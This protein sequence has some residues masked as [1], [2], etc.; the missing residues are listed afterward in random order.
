MS[1]TTSSSE[2]TQIETKDDEQLNL[3]KLIEIIQRQDVDIERLQQD[4]KIL[5]D[6]I[7]EMRYDN[8]V[9]QR[10][11]LSAENN[12]KTLREG[13]SATLELMFGMFK[14]LFA[15]AYEQDESTVSIIKE[16]KLSTVRCTTCLKSFNVRS[17]S[18]YTGS[19]FT[20]PDCPRTTRKFKLGAIAS[21]SK[22]TQSKTIHHEVDS[23]EDEQGDYY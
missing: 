6:M 23:W 8:N 13:I 12:I 4:R 7:Y 5:F 22:P 14:K 3:Q 11:I 16:M 17:N 19:K 1:K 15:K 2:K 18:N 10:S 21:Q 9:I 20:C